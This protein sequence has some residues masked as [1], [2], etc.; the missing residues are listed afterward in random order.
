MKNK[1]YYKAFNPDMT[2]RGKQYAENTVYEES[3]AD[4]CCQA[5]VMH[6]CENPFDCLNYYPLVNENGDISQFAE[7]EPQDE[8]IH[9]GDKCATKKLKICARLGLKGLVEATINFTAERAESNTGGY[10]ARIASGGAGAQIASGADDA[11]IA[12]G[13][14][15]AQ[16]ASNGYDARIASSGYGARI[17]SGGDGAQ[18]ASGGY[19]ARIA[20]SGYGARIASSGYGARIASG[21]DD[22]R[23]ASGGKDAVVAAVGRNSNIKAELGSWIVLAEY[24]KNSIPLCVKSAQ[25][26]GEKLKPGIL[27]T[28]KNGEFVEV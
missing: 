24:D 3:G 28:L 16:I 14:D 19:G 2:C 4:G 5:G 6:F 8:V 21:A 22:A 26:D 9:R 7:V 27:Y 17:A 1:K 11:Q 25:I 15:G 13:A 18:I 20:S 10:G 12:S 23:I